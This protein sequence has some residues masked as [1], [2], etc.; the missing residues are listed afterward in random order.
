M[1]YSWGKLTKHKLL[2]K[3]RSLS[4]AIPQTLVLNKQHFFRLMMKY[5]SVI[6]KPS[7]GKGG[8][9]LIKVTTVSEGI[10]KIHRKKRKDTIIGLSRT[11]DFIRSYCKGVYLVQKM[12]PLAEIDGQPFD[13]RVIVQRKKATWH[14]TGTL[15]KIAG[16][17]FFITNLV[18]SKGRAL[19]I[20]SAIR[21]SNMKGA[22]LERIQARISQLALE[23]AS[24]L[25]KY[26]NMKIVGI[27]L[28][29]DTKGQV[30]IIEA[31]LS[32]DKTYFLRLKDKSMY[33]RI[34]AFSKSS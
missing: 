25:H 20:A 33:R 27:D 22:S 13:V 8:T 3:S 15:A 32:P 16:R 9:G 2:S 11:Y 24:Q 14:V 30:W 4:T 18:E 6:I 26:Y 5:G 12:I 19:P 10:Y 31:N 17:G 1:K 28:G 7:K 21:Q 29:I 34:M 23:T